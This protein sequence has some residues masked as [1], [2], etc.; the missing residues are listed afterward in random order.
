MVAHD[1]CTHYNLHPSPPL[2]APPNTHT[3]STP[4]LPK[5]VEN[6]REGCKFHFPCRPDPP[7]TTKR[8]FKVR[9]STSLTPLGG[10]SGQ[11]CRFTEG[12]ARL[13]FEH[14]GG[15]RC[16]KK[17]KLAKV[18][19]CRG[20]MSKTRVTTACYPLKTRGFLMI[21]WHRLRVLGGSPG[22]SPAD[23]SPPV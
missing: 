18:S 21:Y 23:R 13:F 16:H 9:Y 10:P 6:E 1:H 4:P 14:L 15:P 7:R 11:K 12:I 8:I 3:P 5:N 19:F 22:L 2:P 17:V 20:K